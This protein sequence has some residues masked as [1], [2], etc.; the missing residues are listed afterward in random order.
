MF[1]Q[2]S[3]HNQKQINQK[4]SQGKSYWSLFYKYGENRV[5]GV[6][7]GTDVLYRKFF[8]LRESDAG[9]INKYIYIV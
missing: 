4:K 3:F 7:V 6:G 8:N 9:P 2:N 5:V 1:Q